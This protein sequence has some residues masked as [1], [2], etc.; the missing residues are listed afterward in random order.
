MSSAADWPNAVRGGI[1]RMLARYGADLA[2][3]D[4][5]L[6]QLRRHAIVRCIDHTAT[7]IQVPLAHLPLVRR[8]QE[9][10]ALLMIDDLQADSVVSVTASTTLQ[11][12]FLAV[13]A[14][15]EAGELIGI[16]VAHGGAPRSWTNRELERAGDTALGLSSLLLL[17]TLREHAE[18][19][20]QAE[21]QARAIRRQMHTISARSAE[22]ATLSELSRVL[23]RE[24]PLLLDAAWAIVGV[25]HSESNWRVYVAPER[26]IEFDELFDGVDAPGV[27]LLQHAAT[28][29]AAGEEITT[30]EVP[31]WDLIRNSMS[32]G[33]ERL[34][35]ATL[36][37]S[38]DLS[39]VLLC[40]FSAGGGDV[41]TSHLI[42]ELVEDVRR[43]VGRT[44]SAQGQI[45]A[46]SAL[47]R[48]LLPPRIPDLDGFEFGRL[49]NSA[50]DHSRVG[51]DWYD[52]V[53]IDGA[54]TAFVV[55]DVAGHDIRSAALMGQLRHVLASQLRDRRRPAGA[56]AATDRYFADLD[57]KVMATAV[58]I[59]VDQ[60]T[61]TAHVALAG[62]PPPVHL[63][64]DGATLLRPTPGSPIGFGYGGYVEMAKPLLPGDTL[65]AY[66]DGVVENRTGNLSELID[67]FVD[68]LGSAGQT[69]QELVAFLDQ[70]SRRGGECLDDVAALVVRILAIDEPGASNI[71]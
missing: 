21:A 49:Y 15:D 50:A 55:G 69:V 28:L 23:V 67:S 51:G 12:A 14:F 34:V 32:D 71:R 16:L 13:G 39:M 40:G 48:S 27:A 19:R 68:A 17:D 1:G 42:D 57:E 38:N 36:S 53:K 6:L 26:K 59:V 3:E 18:R 63:S 37:S 35:G 44:A 54:T 25:R 5:Y 33:V 9:R 30:A 22:A 47:Q 20:L 2:V 61:Q 66:T 29:D 60:S 4:T 70:H 62:H 8:V 11:G 43:V 31:E 58:V 64:S 41:R 24:T 65:I 46:A 52:I 10:D 45:R 7:E 56:L